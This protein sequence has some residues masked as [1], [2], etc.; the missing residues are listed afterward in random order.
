MRTVE[1]QREERLV[2]GERK[3]KKIGILE[4]FVKDGENNR[5]RI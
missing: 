5:K 4:I 3:R 1:G 2:K